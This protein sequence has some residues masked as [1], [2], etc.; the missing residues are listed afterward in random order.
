MILKN[1]EDF[2]DFYW[3]SLHGEKSHDTNLFRSCKSFSTLDAFSDHCGTMPLRILEIL[4][5]IEIGRH[6]LK[7]FRRILSVWNG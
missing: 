3:S 1:F 2:Y 5:F 6:T 7:L 4:L